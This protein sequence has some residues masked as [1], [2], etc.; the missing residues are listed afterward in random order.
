MLAGTAAAG[1]WLAA[2]SYM[3]ALGD[4]FPPAKPVLADEARHAPAQPPVRVEPCANVWQ[5]SSDYLRMWGETPVATG[6][7][8]DMESPALLG[9]FM[10]LVSEDGTWTA[11]TV[12]SDGS[13]CILARGFNFT[14]LEP[15]ASLEQLK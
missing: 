5:L 14:G 6:T 11:L 12:D 15:P 8:V 7:L 9:T 4:R 10:L 13:A 3:Q 2:G 1:T